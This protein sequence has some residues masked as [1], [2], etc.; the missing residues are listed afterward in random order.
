MTNTTLSS[1][2]YDTALLKKAVIESF[3]KLTPQQQWKNPVMF[4][5]YLGSILTTILWLQAATGQGEESA[6][7]ILNVTLWLR[8]KQS[9]SRIFA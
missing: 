1:S 7:F 9:S 4:V 8:S 6:S 2:L 5:V 3:Y